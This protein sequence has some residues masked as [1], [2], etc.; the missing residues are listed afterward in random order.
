MTMA[1]SDALPF[2]SERYS[3]SE[4]DLN[5]SWE[6]ANTKGGDDFLGGQA[7]PPFVPFAALAL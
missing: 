1:A 7:T 5:V 2:W 3:S 6:L 4:M